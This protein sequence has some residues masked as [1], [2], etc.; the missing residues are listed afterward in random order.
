MPTYDYRCSACGHAL[1]V[2]QSITEPRKRTCPRCKK[3]KLERLIGQG[4]GFL[5]KG[6]GFYQT[7]YRSESYKQS[8]SAEKSGS[9]KSDAA[10]SKSDTTNTATGGAVE[11]PAAKSAEK[12]APKK[13][14]KRRKSDD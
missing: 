14:E 2:F 6:G 7:D 3:P 9:S 12:T 1:E 8:E 5:F 11:K 4:A 10:A 13:P